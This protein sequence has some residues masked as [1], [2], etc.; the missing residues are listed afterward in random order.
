MNPEGLSFSDGEMAW[1]SFNRAI[2]KYQRRNSYDG[3]IHPT[4][5]PI[6]LYDWIFANYAKAGDL[7]L[8]THVGSGSS[9]IAANKAGL[10]FIGYEINEEYFKAQE[11]RFNDFVSQCRLW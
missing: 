10:G 11:K 1:T 7:I 6:E 9:R 2:R 5:K 3:K 8:D 4:Q